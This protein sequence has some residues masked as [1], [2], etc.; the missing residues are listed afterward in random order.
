MLLFGYLSKSL[1]L[2]LVS[3]KI[4]SNQ[5]VKTHYQVEKA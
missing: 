3:S 1:K 2:E 5:L 4:L